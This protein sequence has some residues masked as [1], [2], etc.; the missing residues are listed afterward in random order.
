MATERF[1]GYVYALELERR[2]FYIGITTDIERRIEQHFTGDG[3]RF[4]RS[5]KPI[6]VVEAFLTKDIYAETRLVM[7]YARMFGAHMVRGDE[8]CQTWDVV[9]HWNYDEELYYMRQS[10]CYKH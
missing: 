2:Y 6:R 4:T 10:I 5:H 8:W 7:Q 3:A 9:P 1:N